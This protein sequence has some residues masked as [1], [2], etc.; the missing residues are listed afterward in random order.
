MELKNKTVAIDTMFFIYYFEGSAFSE[1]IEKILKKVESGEAKAVTTVITLSEILAKPLEH[2]NLPLADEYKNILNSFPNLTVLEIN[3][4]LA[5]LAA[6]VRAKYKI[7]LPDA[8]QI[9]GGLV[10]NADLFIT[11]DKKLKKITEIKVLSLDRD[12]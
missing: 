4:Y 2:K 11:N 9:A 7:K 8:L 1:K 10:S 6:G 12:F 5:T 3:Q